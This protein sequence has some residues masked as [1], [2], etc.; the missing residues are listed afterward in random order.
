MLKTKK[1]T[2]RPFFIFSSSLE[3]LN[4]RI[5]ELTLKARQYSFRR[6]YKKVVMVADELVQISPLPGRYFQALALSQQGRS[7][8]TDKANEIFRELAKENLLPVKAAALLALG[9]SAYQKGNYPEVGKFIKEAS[10]YTTQAPL[11]MIMC[12][13]LQAATHSALGKY[14]ESLLIYQKVM[15]RLFAYAKT[16][17]A[18]VNGELNN[19]AYDLSQFGENELASRIINQVVASPFASKYPEWAETKR[20]IVDKL[21]TG[22]SFKL[23]EDDY[24]ISGNNFQR[25]RLKFNKNY[26]P[27]FL[28][29]HLSQ[30]PY[31]HISLPIND[32]AVKIIKVHWI[33][34]VGKIAASC[35]EGIAV[36]SFCGD[37]QV[38]KNKIGIND[39][40]K[41]DEAVNNTRAF[42]ETQKHILT[43]DQQAG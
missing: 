1:Q 37:E 22:Y 2:L 18:F 25:H 16:L 9:A 15:P 21:Q 20:G 38:G 14:E 3:K 39:L 36:D 32:N 35:N 26:Q 6:D 12:E 8:T 17:P 31:E 11:T 33:V 28:S 4:A 43:S 29:I 42:S 34:T 23:T 24:S 5:R 27:K 10:K 13:T 19:F 7:D 41:L 40:S 30:K